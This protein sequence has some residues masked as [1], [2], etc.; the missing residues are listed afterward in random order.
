MCGAWAGRGLSITIM[1]MV[2]DDLFRNEL[3]IERVSIESGGGHCNYDV[4]CHVSRVT[5]LIRAKTD[6]NS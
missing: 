1:L 2:A 6:S 4:P 3:I 5:R